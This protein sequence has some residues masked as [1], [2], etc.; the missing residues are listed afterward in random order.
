MEEKVRTG[1]QSPM[2]GVSGNRLAGEDEEEGR[3]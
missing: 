3:E 2:A 1:G